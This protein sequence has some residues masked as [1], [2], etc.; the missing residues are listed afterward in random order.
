[1]TKIMAGT[2]AVLMMVTTASSLA[3]SADEASVTAPHGYNLKEGYIRNNK[4]SG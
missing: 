4:Q 2:L 1:M 3:V